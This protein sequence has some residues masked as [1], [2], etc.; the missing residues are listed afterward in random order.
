MWPIMNLSK[1][2]LSNRNFAH[3]DNKHKYYLLNSLQPI[4]VPLKTN[5]P[6]SDKIEYFRY[7]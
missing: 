3:N 4:L 7:I 2:D 6:S 5:L 1:I